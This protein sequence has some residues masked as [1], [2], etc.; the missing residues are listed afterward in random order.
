MKTNGGDSLNSNKID[1]I[2]LATGFRFV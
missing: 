2:S 1:V